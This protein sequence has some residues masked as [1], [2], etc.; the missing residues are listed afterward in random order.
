M[1]YEL[2]GIQKDTNL[3]EQIYS[4]QLP[5]TLTISDIHQWMHSQRLSLSINHNNLYYLVRHHPNDTVLLY[6]K[7]KFGPPT[8]DPRF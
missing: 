5:D 6:M 8:Q 3:E 7:T 2:Y 1:I 4:C